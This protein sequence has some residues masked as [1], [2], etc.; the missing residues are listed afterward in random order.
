[1]TKLK[2]SS[3]LGYLNTDGW[4]ASDE[5]GMINYNTSSDNF[6]KTEEIIQNRK[7]FI[8]LKINRMKLNKTSNNDLLISKYFSNSKLP[9]FDIKTSPNTNKDIIQRR[10]TFTKNI[11]DLLKKVD[12][13]PRDN[14]KRSCN[15]YATLLK[16]DKFKGIRLSEN[17]VSVLYLIL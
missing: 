2:D 7:N 1:M 13:L 9:T 11:S 14:K 6:L 10:V 4:K 5:Y 17:N 16:F 3:Q 8:K 15:K 12:Y